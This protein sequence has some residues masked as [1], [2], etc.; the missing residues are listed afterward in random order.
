MFSSLKSIIRFLDDD[1]QMMSKRCD[2]FIVYDHINSFQFLF[3][4]SV[5]RNVNVFVSNEF[6]NLCDAVAKHPFGCYADLLH[7]ATLK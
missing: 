5:S 2:D 4:V 7:T 1:V 6:V 3:L